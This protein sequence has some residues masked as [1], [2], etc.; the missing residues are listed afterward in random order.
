[1]KFLNTE[2]NMYFITAYIRK[3]SYPNRIIIIHLTDI[4]LTA[5]D[6]VKKKK[7]LKDKLTV[8]PY[9]NTFKTFSKLIFET[10]FIYYN[11]KKISTL[12]LKT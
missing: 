1:M 10:T 5:P 7:K 12:F 4:K 6:T 9:S 3:T 11:L 2:H 8:M